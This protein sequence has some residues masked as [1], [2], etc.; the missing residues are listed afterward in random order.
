MNNDQLDRLKVNEVFNESINRPFLFVYPDTILLEPTTF[1]A[2]GPEIYVDGLVVVAELKKD[3]K[4]IQTP[5]GSIGGRD[6]LSS[7]L[8]GDYNHLEDFFPTYD[9]LADHGRDDGE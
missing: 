7:I 8:G 1:L 5:I 2:I 4:K 9:C 3:G 6:V